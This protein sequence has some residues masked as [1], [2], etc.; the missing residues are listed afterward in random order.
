M[1]AYMFKVQF[2]IQFS[3][4]FSLREFRPDHCR[5]MVRTYNYCICNR[6]SNDGN[7]SG[8]D[9]VSVFGGQ[10]SL[11]LAVLAWVGEMDKGRPE[12]PAEPGVS[13]VAERRRRW[14]RPTGGGY[15]SAS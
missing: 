2:Q 3:M 5:Y 11:T 1:K 13:K 6:G 14:S 10:H 15:L 4:T 7:S 8:I 9:E 12:L